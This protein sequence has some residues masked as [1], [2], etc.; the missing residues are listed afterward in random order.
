MVCR[1]R[2]DRRGVAAVELAVLLPLLMFLFLI[3]VDWA[4]I[5]YYTL[6]VNS[7]ARNG[8]M[9]ASESYSSILSPYLT[10]SQAA[11]ADAPNLIP[12]PTVDAPVYGYDATTSRDYV[13]CTV[14]YNF[15][16][17]ANYPGIPNNTPI[18]RTVRMHLAPRVPN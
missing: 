5:V 7:C 6:T 10:I 9:W 17:V 16:T 14:R 13:Q 8:A 18:V 4:R 3:T 2:E 1:V 15:K 12:P 11:L